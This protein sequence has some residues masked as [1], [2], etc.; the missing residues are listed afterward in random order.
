MTNKNPFVKRERLFNLLKMPT[1]VLYY[2]LADWLT[3]QGYDVMADGDNYIVGLPP[4]GAPTTTI[5]LVAHI[6]TLATRGHQLVETNGVVR[7]KKG[8]LG[9]D[10]R[11]GVYAIM[12]LVEGSYVKPIVIFTNY[13][14][15]GGIGVDRLCRDGVL[16][17]FIDR[18]HLFIEMDRKGRNEFV[19]YSDKLPKAIKKFAK[20]FGFVE[21][22]GTFSD[23]ATLTE[24]Y[25]VPHLNLSIGYYDQHKLTERLVLAEMVETMNKVGE[26]M[27]MEVP[28]C[29]IPKWYDELR[30]LEMAEAAVRQVF[31]EMEDFNPNGHF[32]IERPKSTT[33]R[34][35]HRLDDHDD[36]IVD[37][38]DPDLEDEIERL[39][40]GTDDA[41]IRNLSGRKI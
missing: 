6:D 27:L 9:A 8:V 29:P 28:L 34:I 11:A 23:V 12:E 35:T 30:R 2:Y 40:W 19:Y 16:D 31:A 26:M 14:E 33:T 21:D 1:K 24:H 3:G 25:G 13:E 17:T 5:S 7:N 32:R 36:L 4:A 37:N 38:Y 20:S 41:A 15:S 10:D 22:W 39:G 18:I